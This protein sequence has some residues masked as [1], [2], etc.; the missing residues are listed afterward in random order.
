MYSLDRSWGL[1]AR[2]EKT[3]VIT[4]RTTPPQYRAAEAVQFRWHRA[5]AGASHVAHHA[6]MRTP[7]LAHHDPCARCKCGS[8]GQ[9]RDPGRIGSDD[10]DAGAHGTL[11]LELVENL[12]D[13]LPIPQRLRRVARVSVL[14][15]FPGRLQ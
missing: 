15:L 7:G 8:R 6:A 3:E 14:P 4:F 13:L 5:P 10:R 2:L 9:R 12:G 11:R 1:M